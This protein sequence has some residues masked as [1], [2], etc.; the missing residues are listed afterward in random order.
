MT[1]LCFARKRRDL[2]RKEMK[3]SH[4]CLD[5]PL[6]I[7]YNIKWIIIERKRWRRVWI[8][9]APRGGSLGAGMGILPRRLLR[10]LPPYEGEDGGVFHLL[11]FLRLR[12]LRPVR[13]A[14][15]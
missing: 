14:L 6:E 2:S 13:Y 10:S 7:K 3:T 8:R 4:F 5:F 15:S 9:E 12:V 1:F 11:P